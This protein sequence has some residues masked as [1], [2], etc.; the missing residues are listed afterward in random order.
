[1]NRLL[2]KKTLYI[3]G[4]VIVGIFVYITLNKKEV[5]K[6]VEEVKKTELSAPKPQVNME[7]PSKIVWDINEGNWSNKTKIYIS[8]KTS[9]E[10]TVELLMSM[11]GL[12]ITDKTLD[13]P[14]LL[15]YE[16][17]NNGKTLIVTKETGK[18]SYS[19]NYENIPKSNLI[20]DLDGLKEKAKQFVKTVSGN[21]STEIKF[22][23]TNYFKMVYPRWVESGSNNFDMVE[24]NGSLSLD[25]IEVKTYYENA[26]VLRYSKSG[27]LL[28]F[29]YTPLATITETKEVESL[30]LDEVKGLAENQFIVYQKTGNEQFDL[31]E[32]RNISGAV[33]LTKAELIYI[34]S[35]KGDKIWP[36][37]SFEGNTNSET[38]PVKVVIITSAVK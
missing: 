21:E 22:D 37:L 27:I 30:S 11:T 16:N 36:Y 2:N 19:Q 17:T 35:D 4:F 13:D 38:G 1:M 32:E 12:K 3:L 26:I 25:N 29:D 8:Q 18:I 6:T 31:S 28:K 33:T 7:A 20:S 10:K 5:E 34:Q 24:L 14:K 15:I 9:Y 23:E